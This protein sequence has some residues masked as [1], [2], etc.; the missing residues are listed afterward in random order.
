MRKVT[1]TLI[2][3]VLVLMAGC[4]YLQPSPTPLQQCESVCNTMN[5][6]AAGDVCKQK[7][8]ESYIGGGTKNG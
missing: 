3:L 7:C 8:N 1:T 2:I 4:T 6:P 5:S